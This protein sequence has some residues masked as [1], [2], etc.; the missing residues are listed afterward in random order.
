MGRLYSDKIDDSILVPDGHT[1]EEDTPEVNRIKE[2]T[3]LDTLNS[4]RPV[5]HAI[6]KLQEP[7]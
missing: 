4:E 2:R 3:T 1:T 7:E 5:D 6:F